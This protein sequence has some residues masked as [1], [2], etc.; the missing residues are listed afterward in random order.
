MIETLLDA[1]LRC[2]ALTGVV[3]LC[4]KLPRL[5]NPHIQLTA[6][7]VVLVASLLMPVATRLAAFVIPP[8]PVAASIIDAVRALRIEEPSLGRVDIL[9]SP[10]AIEVGPNGPGAAF[11]PAIPRVKL[12]VAAAVL[13]AIVA[14]V[15]LVRMVAG[16]L[17]TLRLMRAAKPLGESW[18][19]GRDIRASDNLSAPATFGATILLPQDYVDWSETKLSAVLAHEAAHARRGD[20]YI[21]I[22]AMLNRAIFWFNP[23]SWWL[24]R[25]LAQLAEAASDDA[26]LAGIKDRP[27]YA[28]ILLELAHAP[29]VEFGAV[30]MA[31]PATVRARIE[32]I[33]AESATP[34]EI[35]QRGR[36]ILVAATLPLVAAAASPLTAPSAVPPGTDEASSEHAFPERNGPDRAFYAR[37]SSSS[38]DVEERAITPPSVGHASESALPQDGVEANLAHAASELAAVRPTPEVAPTTASLK[39]AETQPTEVDVPGPNLTTSFATVPQGDRLVVRDKEETKGVQ[40]VGNQPPLPTAAALARFVAA[41]PLLRPIGKDHSAERALGQIGKTERPADGKGDTQNANVTRAQTQ[42]TAA[43]APD[44]CVHSDWTGQRAFLICHAHKTESPTVSSAQPANSWNGAWTGYWT[45]TW[46]QLFLLSRVTI[47]DGAVVEYISSGHHATAKATRV[48]NSAISFDTPE[49]RITLTRTGQNFANAIK[50]DTFTGRPLGSQYG[51]G[52]SGGMFAR[53]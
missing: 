1:A 3:W 38:A 44:I 28:E 20:F 34:L 52:S 31:R 5:R 2:A 50:V 32:R 8:A 14:G 30:A 33:L 23:L 24:Q 13:Y 11:A 19:V 26:A 29:P 45:G 15:F 49:S 36:A 43:V 47:K 27:L 7:T 18:A 51:A 53:R 12:A 35:G 21:Q 46:G 4:L 41:A 16:L 25:R 22:A 40:S 37:D 39:S 42:E 9:A 6:W 48:T 10:Q 17:L